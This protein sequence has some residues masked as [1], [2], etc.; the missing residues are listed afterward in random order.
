M[1][2]KLDKP[3]TQNQGKLTVSQKNKICDLFASGLGYV[4]IKH[5]IFRDF[6]KPFGHLINPAIH[7]MKGI[8]KQLMVDIPGSNSVAKLKEKIEAKFP[9]CDTESLDHLISKIL[10]AGTKEGTFA[11]YKSKC[12]KDLMD[13]A[14]IK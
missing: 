12:G 10:K 11:K 1:F 7:K 9:D 5:K 8:E 14:V 4:E 3:E 2:K 13:K 6:D